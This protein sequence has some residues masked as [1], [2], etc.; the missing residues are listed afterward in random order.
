MSPLSSVGGRKPVT[1]HGDFTTTS[2]LSGAHEVLPSS[3][4]AQIVA[5]SHPNTVGDAATWTATNGELI[6]PLTSKLEVA[7]QRRNN[8]SGGTVP[9]LT[10]Q[11]RPGANETGIYSSA[12]I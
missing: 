9:M 4:T 1:P 12:I 3:L 11:G 10:L 6:S 5:E 2:S 8:P 7:M